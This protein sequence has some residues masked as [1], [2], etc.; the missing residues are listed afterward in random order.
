MTIPS[1][2]L[3]AA[4][5]L[6][7]LAAC[8]YDALLLAGMFFVATFPYVTLIGGPPA[9]WLARIGL[10]LYLFA[11]GFLFFAWFWT[12]GGQTLGMRAWRLRV[13]TEQGGAIGWRQATLRFAA[14]LLSWICLGAGFWWALLDPQQRAW[15]D[16]L[17]RTRLVVMP[18][19]A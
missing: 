3:P 19:R 15:H 16:R 9:S 14:A 5:L 2:A 17:S 11:L 1:S 8:A 13:V 7:R 4:G 12:H 10:Q 6:R 18:K